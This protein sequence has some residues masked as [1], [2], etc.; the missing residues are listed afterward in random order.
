MKQAARL[1]IETKLN[2]LVVGPPGTGKTEIIKQVAQDVC[3]EQGGEVMILHPV[4]DDPTDYKG[5][6]FP[7]EDRK[8]ANFL[9]FGNLQRM[10]TAERLLICI[11]DDAGQA[12]PSVQAAIMQ[13]VQERSINGHK[14]SDMCR[15]FL[16]TNRK[17]DKAGVTGILEP[18]KSRCIIVSLDVHDDDWR[19]WA[20][21]AG[22]PPELIAFSKL[23]PEMLH[24]FA[25][26]SD[27]SNSPNPR[28]W[29][30]AGRLMAAGMPKT[31]E[32]ELF[33][34]C[35]GEQWASE[36]SA[37]LRIYREMPDPEAYIRDPE[38]ELPENE[39]VLYALAAALSYKAT[40][41]NVEQIFNVS[42]R[43]GAE[44]STFLVFSMVQRDKKLAESTGMA[45][46]AKKFAPYLL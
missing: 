16:L 7:S 39:S 36:F 22:M 30:H 40:K 10:I 28:N 13:V 34:G 31:L 18:L 15:F 25:P 41:K 26:T 32:F 27:I 12:A 4:C 21:G 9:P 37:F 3:D 14:I 20:A 17:G 8:A 6:G 45:A 42:M 44:Y 5:L 11:F 29:E 35:N 23:R 1:A 19:Q 38:K 24:K 43:L 33:R 2:M 46:W